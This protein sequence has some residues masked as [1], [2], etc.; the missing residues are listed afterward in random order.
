MLM[1]VLASSGRSKDALRQYS[2]CVTALRSVL[3]TEP[4]GITN[5][6]RDKI[7]RGQLRAPAAK[8][9]AGWEHV[10]TRL[11]GT[12]GPPPLRGRSKALD[13]LDEFAS[14]SGGALLLIGE[15]GVG[16]TRFSIEAAR[17]CAERGAVVLSGLGYDF[18]RPAPYT[19]FV[20]AWSDHHRMMGLSPD[21]NPFVSFRPIPGASA[22]EDRMR[23]FQL[24]ERA[25]SDLAGDGP[26]CI[27]L[28]DLHQA[29]ESSLFLF[30]HLA[31]ASRHLPLKLIGT[32]R[33][34]GVVV[35]NALHKLLG[36][37]ARERLSTRLPLQRLDREATRE[38]VADLGQGNLGDD[39][40]DSVY[41]LAEGNPFFTEEV[42]RAMVD[43][44]TDQPIVSDD[45]LATVHG[46]AAALGREAERF[47][48]AA[49]VHGTRFFFEVVCSATGMDQTAALDA[50]D[51]G[52]KARIIEEYDDPSQYRF[53]HAL[54]R[55]ALFESLSHARRV[56]IHRSI[57][58]ALE[59]HPRAKELTEVLAYQHKEAGQIERAIPHLRAAAE[60]AQARLGFGEAVDFC[61]QALELMETVG[62]GD[63]PDRLWLLRSM[64]A[65][66]VALGD[67]D[68]A[69]E[70]L[71]AA[72]ALEGI[73]GWRPTEPQ[74]ANA[75]RLAAL[76][77]IE[78]GELSAAEELLDRASA[79]LSEVADDPE[80]GSVYYLFS[81]LRWHQSR[82]EE[83]FE[84]AQKCLQEA[85][86]RNDPEAI[87]KGYEMLALACHSLGDWK[88]GTEYEQQRSAMADAP[89]DVAS[90]FDIHL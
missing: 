30:H 81:Q 48:V 25:V 70:N 10:A 88:K 20:D 52:L 4:S 23:L 47:L 36:G 11:L 55:Q 59:G 78:R 84:L 89:L 61:Q 29:D 73:D 74:R 1:S 80:R 63:G 24:V 27:V 33:E 65:M 6:L 68:E 40:V 17:R 56:Y 12:A 54:M 44:G 39:A 2:E 77:H 22:Q 18:D 8:S 13:V 49:S 76:A 72:A 19:V 7:E 75:L 34:E 42:V 83:A 60:R 21:D 37:L 86:R 53:R 14:S 26:I 5:A 41:R 50:L 82:H 57:A 87:G 85:E 69:I 62:T 71:L 35:G 45:L 16:K 43:A 28:E 90:A 66:R 9:K 64:G 3:D 15:A 51:L 32:L 46:R 31:R 79:L 67:L 58:D 38:L